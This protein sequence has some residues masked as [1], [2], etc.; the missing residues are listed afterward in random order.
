VPT[1]AFVL[2]GLTVRSWVILG[3][4]PFALLVLLL[5]CAVKRTGTSWR[6][7]VLSTGAFAAGLAL[8]TTILP[9]VIGAMAGGLGLWVLAQ[10]LLG[11]R[12]PPLAV[13]GLG[14]AATVAVGRWG[15]LL[16]GCCFGTVTDLP[17][18]R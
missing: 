8:G 17:R 18:R 14:L 4:L 6:T 2:G 11:V 10:R 1:H 7:A 16:N 3:Q 13:A 12:R 15:C 5:L 9:S